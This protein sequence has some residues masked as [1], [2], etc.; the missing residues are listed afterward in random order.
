MV[1]PYFDVLETAASIFGI[2]FA[3]AYPAFDMLSTYSFMD[4]S[5]ALGKDPIAHEG[6]LGLKKLVPRF[7]IEKGLIVYYFIESGILLSI[8]LVLI[9]LTVLS[10]FGV[11]ALLIFDGT[12][13]VQGS[14]FVRGNF[15]AA[16][17]LRKELA[18]RIGE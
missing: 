18:E 13:I 11:V 7:G 9:G 14:R 5:R 2:Y 8:F 15:R 17:G 12:G 1:N 16:K 3:F 4:P 6:A 10:P